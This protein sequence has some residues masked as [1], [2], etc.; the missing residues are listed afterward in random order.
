MDLDKYLDNLKLEDI[1]S[2]DLKTFYQ[3][4]TKPEVLWGK[5]QL[6]ELEALKLYI[7]DNLAMFEYVTKMEFN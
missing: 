3:L 4:S 5:H 7:R 6:S 1:S 2:Y